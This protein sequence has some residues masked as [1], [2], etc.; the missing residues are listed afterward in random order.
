MLIL[1]TCMTVTADLTP[2]LLHRKRQ[3]DTDSS[4]TVSSQL[5]LFLCAL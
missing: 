3:F 2:V 4:V 1:V 5:S